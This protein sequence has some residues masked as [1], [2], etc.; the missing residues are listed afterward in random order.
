MDKF[1]RNLIYNLIKEHKCKKIL[2]AGCGTGRILLFL[3]SKGLKCWG[4]DPSKNMLSLCK[5]KLKA[6]KSKIELKKGDIEK[7]PYKNNTFDCTYTMHVLMHMPDYKKA[8]KEMHRVTKK[9]GIIICDF[10]N[11]NSPWTKISLFL[12]PEM[13]RTQLF[14]IKELEKFFGKYNYTMTGLFSYARTFYKIPIIRYIILFLEHVLPL[15]LS[16]K[17]QLIVIVKK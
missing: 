3:A 10:P 6:T 17:T 15:P 1:Q 12:N 8:F 16:W 14:T 9:K 2:E 4:I 13:K 7:I 11:K 5:E